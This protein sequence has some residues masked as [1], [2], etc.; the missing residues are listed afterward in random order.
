MINSC[1]V[2]AISMCA[3]MMSA[4]TPLLRHSVI[5]SLAYTEHLFLGIHL[6]GEIWYGCSDMAFESDQ[7]LFIYLQIWFVLFCVSRMLHI[8]KPVA[9]FG[10]IPP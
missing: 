1:S 5:S 2:N 6:F 8:P 3:M 4:H 9:S 10:N 7:F